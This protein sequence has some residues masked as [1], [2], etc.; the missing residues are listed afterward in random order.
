MYVFAEKGGNYTV[1]W[2]QHDC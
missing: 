2:A 1:W